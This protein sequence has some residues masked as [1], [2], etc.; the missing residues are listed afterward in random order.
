VCEKFRKKTEQSGSRQQNLS[1][2]NESEVETFAL[3]SLNEIGY[4][5]PKSF[6]Y[7]EDCVRNLIATSVI[8]GVHYQ[9][10]ISGFCYVL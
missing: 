3:Q 2:R 6:L 7:T 1:H 5:F 8:V 10:D 4:S 9:S